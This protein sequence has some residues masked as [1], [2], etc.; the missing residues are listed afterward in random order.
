MVDGNNTDLYQLC[1]RVVA[2]QSSE[3]GSLLGFVTVK[4][5]NQEFNLD[6]TLPHSLC[7]T[8]YKMHS[9]PVLASVPTPTATVYAVNAVKHDTS[10]VVEATQLNHSAATDATMSVNTT[11]LD[12]HSADKIVV[13]KDTRSCQRENEECDESYTTTRYHQQQHSHRGKYSVEQ[14]VSSTSVVNKKEGTY[15]VPQ[16]IST[17]SSHIKKEKQ[18]VSSNGGH[19]VYFR[20]SEARFGAVTIGSLTRT[21]IDL[22][23]GTD[24]EVSS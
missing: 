8:I 5:D 20:L 1:R 19:G 6:V 4:Q 11:K 22:C 10:S 13:N 24:N 12:F 14:Q 21:R 16:K 9:A 2:S 7:Q 23:N 17:S 18:R 15:A 3:G